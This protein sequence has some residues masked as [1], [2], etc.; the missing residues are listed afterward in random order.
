MSQVAGR[1]RS[2]NNRIAK[3]WETIRVFISSTFRDMH[4]ERDYLV[5]VVFPKLR[6]RLE[7]YQYHLEDIDLRWGV[8]ADQANNDMALDLCLQQIDECRPF[9]VGILGERY[10]WVPKSF[11]DKA[12]SKYGWIQRQTGKSITELE[13]LYGVLKKKEMKGHAFFYF[14]DNA[15]IADVPA[16][17]QADILSEDEESA[18]KLKVLKDAIRQADPP[19][20]YFDGYPCQY[21]GLKVNSRILKLEVNESD[22]ETLKDVIKDGFVELDRYAQLDDNLK[23]VIRRNA[24][25]Y[26]D[27]LKPFGDRV[28]DQLW[29]AIKL[30]HHLPDTPPID[31]LAQ[32]DPLAYEAQFHERFIES[33]TRIY[34]GQEK[35]QRDLMQYANGDDT[36]PCLVTG[37]SGSGKSAVLAR[38]AQNLERQNKNILLIPHFVGASP[39]ST[40]LRQI[41]R[42]F[43]EILKAKLHYEDEIPFDINKLIDCFRKFINNVPSDAPVVILIDALNQ[44]DETDHAHTMSWLPTTLP[45]HVKIIASCIDDTGQQESVLQAFEHRQYHH[46]KL[47]PL[48]TNERL[49]IVRVVPSL[50]AKSLDAK[51]VRL[52]LDNKATDN[53]LFLLVA[54]EELRGFGSFEHVSDRIRQLP[55]GKNANTEIFIQVIERL[56]DEFD[57]KIVEKVLCYLA[58][59]RIGM[60]ERE[61]L[62]LFEGVDAEASKSDLFPILR[63]LR[64]YLQYRGDAI[65]FFHRNLFKAVRNRY[66]PDDGCREPYH[67]DLAGYFHL[68]LNPPGEE[69]WAGGYVRALSELPHHQISGLL[70]EPLE[71]TLTALPFLEAKTRAG[72]VFELAGDFSAAIEALP[73]DRPQRRILQLLEE[74]LRRDIHF[75]ARHAVDYPQALFQCFWNTCIWDGGIRGVSVA[76]D[77]FTAS[78]LMRQWQIDRSSRGLATLW[79]RAVRAHPMSEI[80]VWA[81]P[82][83]GLE[84]AHLAFS[85]DGELLA[86]LTADGRV[87]A[88]LEAG[89]GKQVLLEEGNALRISPI[90]AESAFFDSLITGSGLFSDILG[91]SFCRN[92][93]AVAA[94]SSGAV[95]IWDVRTGNRSVFL[96]DDQVVLKAFCLSHKANRIAVG[97][98]DGTVQIW[99]AASGVRLTHMNAH[100]GA[101][102]GLTFL[103]DGRSLVSASEDGTVRLW[104]GGE[105]QSSSFDLEP[106]S[107]LA[108]D[109]TTTELFCS[110][111]KTG[112]VFKFV[113][114]RL[115]QDRELSFLKSVRSLSVSSESGYSVTCSGGRVSLWNTGTTG[116]TREKVLPVWECDARHGVL[117][118]DG[119]KVALVSPDGAVMLLQARPYMYRPDG[120]GSGILQ[121]AVSPDG[122]LVSVA[123][124]QD[125][126]RVID[127]GTGRVLHSLDLEGRTVCSMC[128]GQDSQTLVAGIVD[129]RVISW[130]PASGDCL[131]IKGHLNSV[132]YVTVSPDGALVVSS[133]SEGFARCWDLADGGRKLWEHPTKEG[134]RYVHDTY[135]VC[136]SCDGRHVAIIRAR[137]NVAVYESLTGTR[138]ATVS[139]G[140]PIT[141]LA[142]S[143][144]GNLLCAGTVSGHIHAWAWPEGVEVARIAADGSVLSLWV[145]AD[146]RRLTAAIGEAPTG[147]SWPSY[148]WLR[149]QVCQQVCSYEIPSGQKRFKITGQGPLALGAS[150]GP[151]PP[152]IGVQT[153]WEVALHRIHDGE[154]ISR[155]AYWRCVKLMDPAMHTTDANEW[156][157]IPIGTDRLGRTVAVA[158]G[159]EVLVYRLEGADPDY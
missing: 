18:A 3:R 71:T 26:L 146:C 95:G 15:F 150:G 60:T 39:V 131:T 149:R 58:C 57:S 51:Q 21:N 74:A 61:L 48:T 152:V 127:T 84:V 142:M 158:W 114:G 72:L 80:L 147:Q 27:D 49:E 93:N 107:A 94:A 129:G 5:K 156:E 100:E 85:P 22:W 19:L 90:R 101:V 157:R 119:M 121:L 47:K 29:Q 50:S 106:I 153:E 17:K 139:A 7:A 123:G 154:V 34:I 82:P 75:I 87:L 37:P 102:T 67:R 99:D 89:S 64:P 140:W 88:L 98:E 52:L 115:T 130:N 77:G 56:S 73:I 143:S 55:Q 91:L 79:L 133:S 14:R 23:E 30:E 9:F 148:K 16:W 110:S 141:A 2:R 8:T 70:W 144:E 117:S 43:C 145:S 96:A 92:G 108:M 105:G 103:P 120:R 81:V 32:D 25:V 159:E 54:L 104:R 137:T 109:M 20:P 53:P 6:E 44:M 155:L 62:E 122:A 113:R 69:A 4:A 116:T 138:V 35:I 111:R 38:F 97:F 126:I 11:S 112:Y 65:D 40:S 151:E 63:Q 128:F 136:F 83:S 42:R 41:L 125:G 59:S 124:L 36:V 86:T 1:K 33:R 132:E 12:V 31:T 13:I 10:G 45:W 68:L 134:L 24:I 28:Y 118:P 76:H 135:P 66:L 78:G 46:I